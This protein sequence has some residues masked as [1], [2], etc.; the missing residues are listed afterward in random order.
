MNT[1]S[2]SNKSSFPWS[3]VIEGHEKYYVYLNDE[4]SN[5]M[6]F[7][8]KNDTPDDFNLCFEMAWKKG[9]KLKENGLIS[10]FRVRVNNDE[11]IGSPYVELLVNG[12]KCPLSEMF[13]KQT[14]ATST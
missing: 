11:F 14:L 1:S 5:S 13:K 7:V 9:E 10:S 6:V 3:N 4:F 2:L 12:N 8:Q